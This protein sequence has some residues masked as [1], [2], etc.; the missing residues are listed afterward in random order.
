M[1]DRR[2]PLFLI[3]GGPYQTRRRGA[4]PL[5]ENVI[6]QAGVKRPRIAYVGAASR[7]NPAFRLIIARMLARAGAGDVTLA[8]MCGRRVDQEKTRRVLEDSDL[9]F[10]SGGDVEEGMKV[11][12]KRGMDSLLTSLHAA[13]KP[14]FGVS[15]GSIML[16]QRWVRWRDPQDDESAELFSCLGLAPVLCD[17]HG[18]SDGWVELQAML[19]LCRVGTSGFGIVSGSALAVAGDGAVTALGGDVHVFRKKKAGVFQEESL[20]E[21]G[22][23]TTRI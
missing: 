7:D 16:S 1:P 11:L 15:A 6:R 23:P 14:F 4:D 18:E 21:S 5:L 17:T 22:K 9:V 19:R 3:A 20:R 8:P 13:G 12:A 2:A 10:I